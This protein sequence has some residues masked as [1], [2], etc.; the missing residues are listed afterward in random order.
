MKAIEKYV[1]GYTKTMSNHK[2]SLAILNKGTRIIES[3]F[4]TMCFHYYKM[5]ILHRS[6]AVKK[7]SS[8]KE[9]EKRAELFN[10][11]FN[12]GMK[13]GD[14][15]H[16]CNDRA[17]KSIDDYKFFTKFMD[18]LIVIGYREGDVLAFC[19][20]LEYSYVK[21]LEWFK[22][23]CNLHYNI[24]AKALILYLSGDITIDILEREF[25]E[26]S[27]FTKTVKPLD[28]YKSVHFIKD[29]I[30]VYE[31]FHEIVDKRRLRAKIKASCSN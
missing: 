2:E 27:I 18:A 24:Y 11:I 7:S 19:R 30:R 26:I 5:M 8:Y 1:V 6:L 12:L 29:M 13:A 23:Q 4:L 31:S 17:D 28:K 14:M 15:M 21:G 25:V 20:Q 10:G 22:Y 9:A 3:L 16:D